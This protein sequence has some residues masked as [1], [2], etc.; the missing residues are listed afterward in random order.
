[1]VAASGETCRMAARGVVDAGAPEFLDAG[2]KEGLGG[3]TGEKRAEEVAGAGRC[4]AR[5]PPPASP[6]RLGLAAPRKEGVFPNRG[7]SV[8]ETVKSGGV[9]QRLD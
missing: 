5:G 6:P 1:M 8:V 3:R 2:R 9:T 7:R 4:G